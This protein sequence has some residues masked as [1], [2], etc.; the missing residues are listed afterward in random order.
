MTGPSF[1][2]RL[3]ADFTR[4][5]RQVIHR[6][7]SGEEHL[8]GDD[9]LSLIQAM[10]LL[11]RSEIVRGEQI[12][13]FAALYDHKIDAVYSDGFIGRLMQLADPESEGEPL[14]A[15]VSRQIVTELRQAGLLQAGVPDLQLLV[16]FCLYW[17]QAFAR[18]YVFEVSICRDL[19]ASRIA[20]VTHDLRDRQA[21]L[22]EY[23]LELMGFR[24]DIKT[25]TYFALLYRSE[26]LSLDFY[27]TRMYYASERS[28]HRAVWLKPSFWRA[29]NGEPTSTP[30]ESIWQVLPGAAQIS[31]R[32]Q[33]F[34]IVLY[35]DWK[36]RVLARQP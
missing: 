21:R 8:S 4:S 34:V 32:G 6:Y 18:G 31:L 20:Y 12:E 7:L 1:V 19:T 26:K 22:S 15:S 14:R 35:E 3:P 30:Y 25:S 13:T 5:H 29:L 9:W 16:A 33:A 2:V 17:W 28:W 10:N 24:G 23:D 36:R 27:I 11:R